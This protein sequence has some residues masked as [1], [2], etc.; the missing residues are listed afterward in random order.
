MPETA[1][2]DRK[3]AAKSLLRYRYRPLDTPGSEG[4]TSP[5]P[6]FQPRVQ[7]ASR[8]THPVTT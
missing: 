2:P 6:V 3:L 1:V 5:P 8:P 7:R 4:E